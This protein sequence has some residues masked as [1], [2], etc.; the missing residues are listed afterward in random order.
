MESSHIAVM[1]G[2]GSPTLSGWKCVFRLGS[3]EADLAARPGDDGSFE[4]AFFRPHPL[5]RM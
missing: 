5:Y 2:R 4:E 1:A 3:R